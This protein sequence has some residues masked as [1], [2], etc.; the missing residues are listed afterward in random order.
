MPAV[1]AERGGMAEPRWRVTS[2]SYVVDSEHLRLRKDR[3][4]LPD[5][6]T[7]EDYYVKESRGF[8]VIFATTPDKRVI[9]V[10]QYKH[11][12]GKTLLELP[13]G[14]IDPG[15]EPLQTAVR[16]FSEETGY[17]G[18]MEHVRTFCTDPTNA[19]TVAHLFYA[20]NVQ[21]AGKQNLGLGED[22]TVELATLDDLHA[23]VRD[24]TIDSVAHVASIYL[25]LDRLRVSS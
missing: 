19:D 24:G 15:E 16:E 11:G 21:L 1:H 4:E 20:P 3:I 14:A 12:I 5:G 25:M 7:I 2:S 22:I 23:F 9:L 8:V 6:R 17:S 10:R 13:A 18:T